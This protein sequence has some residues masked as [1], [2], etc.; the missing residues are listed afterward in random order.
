MRDDLSC[1]GERAARTDRLKIVSEQ[2]SKISLPPMEEARNSSELSWDEPKGSWRAAQAYGRSPFQVDRSYL[3]KPLRVYLFGSHISESLSP[4]VN[5]LVY[6]EL[7]LSWTFSLYTTT[8]PDEFRRVIQEPDV[9]GAS[10]TMPNKLSFMPVAD[11]ITDE[12]R[13]MGA[14][15]TTFVKLDPQGR[16]L[17]IG[18]NTD[19]VGLKHTIYGMPRSE[20]LGRGRPSLVLGSGGAAR[21][22]LFAVWEAVCPSEIYVVNRARSEAEEMIAGLGETAPRVKLRFIGSLDEARTLPAP[23]VIVGTVPD[24]EPETADEEL[25]WQ[26]CTTFVKRQ[27]KDG[28][29]V[30]MS[31]MPSPHTSLCREAE[32]HGATV[33]RGDEVLIQV[34]L[35]QISFW[36]ERDMNT[37]ERARRILQQ[38]READ[39][40]K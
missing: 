9:I 1:A 27:G 32:R 6:K 40:R 4:K 38:I 7:Q 14:M 24:T 34:C 25:A 26:I 19:W 11:V 10:V 31:Y 3:N 15:N 13:A 22:A 20:E 17:H 16:R 28:F 23:A 37:G 33:R 8:D 21:S 35:A 29:V 36:A 2:G 30:D 39:S 12:V 18:T 5:E